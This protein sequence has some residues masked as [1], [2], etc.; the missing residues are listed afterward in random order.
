[1]SYY[2]YCVE[3]KRNDKWDIFG[4]LDW[5]D[6]GH[7]AFYET[8]DE[9]EKKK[10]LVEYIYENEV[11]ISIHRKLIL[12]LCGGTGEWSAP[13]RD[14]GYN[15]VVV[16][17]YAYKEGAGGNAFTGTSDMDV[18]NKT[19]HTP[20]Y[21]G[22]PV[23]GILA[24]PPCTQFASSG[25]RWW[26]EKSIKRPHLLREAVC[27]VHSCKTMI[28]NH[29]P[30]WW[31]M[32]NPVGRLKD[33]MGPHRFTF[34]PCDYAGLA[35]DPHSNQYTKKTCLWGEFE[36]PEKHYMEPVLGSLMWKKYGGKSKKTKR[37]RSATP[38]GFAKAFF[39]ANK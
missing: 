20:G 37:M 12:D 31:A 28:D 16:D 25:A 5:E 30:K 19:L 15:V 9:A 38:Q 14:A 29:K 8:F 13:Y 36:E 26:K 2:H 3:I 24:S 10:F 27:V 11:R 18:K 33:Y 17:P 32:E 23:H 34:D 21:F 6:G 39:T 4:A 22:T 35:D 7:G 1:M